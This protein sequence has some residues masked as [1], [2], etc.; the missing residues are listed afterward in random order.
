[1]GH[2]SGE[3]QYRDPLGQDIILPLDIWYPTEDSSGE[4]A[5]Y[6]DT[7][8]DDLAWAE[9][10]LADAIH[11]DGHPVLV[12]SHGSNLYGASSAFLM[13]HFASHGWVTVAPTHVGNTVV[14]L[15]SGDCDT[16]D[17]SCRS[18]NVWLQRPLNT[19][20]ALDAVVSVLGS[21]P[22]VDSVVLAGFSYGAYDTWIHAGARVSESEL[23]Q[24]CS[25]GGISGGCSDAGIEAISS[26]RRDDRV[27][28]IIPM[29]GAHA[30]PFDMD[31]RSNLDTPV[32]QMSG[33]QDDDDPKWIWDNTENTPMTWLSIE[34]ACHG[35]WSFGGCSDIETIEGQNLISTYALAFARRHLLGDTSEETTTLLDGSY[36]PWPSTDIQRQ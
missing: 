23:R 14:D 28:A 36:I 1:M 30:F 8:N 5:T 13:R 19:V 18:E 7:F 24:A 3:T 6:F 25:V 33:T 17:F 22:S 15:N 31:G 10:S 2:K 4:D 35:L 27:A 12:F 32:L 9:A 29:A 11:N 21:P 20:A 26:L 34:G 16:D